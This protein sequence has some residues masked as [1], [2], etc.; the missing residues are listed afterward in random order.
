MLGYMKELLHEYYESIGDQLLGQK[1][2]WGERKYIQPQNAITLFAFISFVF[3][4]TKL[5]WYHSAF[6]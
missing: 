3:R 5:S 4:F 2:K 6:L 1:I